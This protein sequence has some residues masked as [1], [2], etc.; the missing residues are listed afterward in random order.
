MAWLEQAMAAGIM[1]FISSSA[2][3]R[4]TRHA[5][6]ECAAPPGVALRPSKEL[7][8]SSRAGGTARADRRLRALL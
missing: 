3:C 2:G 5:R 6:R 4:R 7:S 1:A 8:P